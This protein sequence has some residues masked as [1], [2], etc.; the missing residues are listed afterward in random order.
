MLNRIS[1]ADV[2]NNFAKI[3][4]QV[5]NEKKEFILTQHGKELVAIIPINMLYLLQKIE[6]KIDDEDAC[7]PS[8][9]QLVKQYKSGYQKMPEN[10]ESIEVWETVAFDV[11][12]QGEW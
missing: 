7:K 11:F 12:S 2:K 3:V 10:I 5:A 9:D 6:N 1:T 4:N 8:Y